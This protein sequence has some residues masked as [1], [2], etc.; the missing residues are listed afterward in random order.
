MGG[1]GGM[2]PSIPNRRSCL[3]TPK[4]YTQ[5]TPTLSAAYDNVFVFVVM[6]LVIWL[7]TKPRETYSVATGSSGPASCGLATAALFV[8]C[9]PA[10]TG[11]FRTGLSAP[12]WPM[13]IP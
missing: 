7:E 13:I 4:G 2:G 5:P 10:F 1:P 9:L 12:S 11:H 3:W 6:F 8:S